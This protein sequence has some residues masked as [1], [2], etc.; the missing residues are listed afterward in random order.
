MAAR[1]FA[2][3]DVGSYELNL[4]IYE[5]QSGNMKVID[6]VVYRLDL[7]TDSYTKGKIPADKVTELIRILKEFA[8][9]MRS[10]RVSDYKAYG[11]SA[12]RETSNTRILLDQIEQRTNIHIDVLSN[13]EQRFLN[14]KSV[15]SKGGDFLKIIDNGT[16]II[17][18]GGGSIQLSL[19]DNDKLDMTQNVDIGVIRLLDRLK[20]IDVKPSR[21][22]EML[23]EMINSQLSVLNRLYLKNRKITNLII[24]DDYLSP[25]IWNRTRESDTPGYITASRFASFSEKLRQ[26]E[27]GEFA[28]TYSV[29]LENV[30]LVLVAAALMRNIFN[31]TGAEQ[32]WSPGAT[33]TDGIAYEYGEKKKL[34]TINH[35]FE[36]DIVACARGISRRYMGDDKR[37][38]NMEAICLAI[39]DSIKSIHGLNKRDRLIL[40]LAAIL[41]DC[42]KYISLH[43]LSDCSYDIIMSTEI[44]GL[45]HEEREILAGVVKH[46]H[47]FL[48]FDEDK[49]GINIYSDESYMRTAKL[50]AIL[51]LANGLDKSQKQK[52]TNIKASLK[53]P[54]LTLTVRTNKDL[55]LEKGLFSKRADFFEEIY[56]VRP[57]INQIAK[58]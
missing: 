43:N 9:I 13:S 40:R 36:E 26:M 37:A 5:F 52:V 34:I 2:A 46:N 15:A 25:I 54:V 45:S 38:S 1:M 3:I 4:K 51:R 22:G 33:L 57:V 39:Y 58:V 48:E 55:T 19:F 18:I 42:G 32:M 35:N 56:N 20:R 12:I 47:A 29:P 44:I 17:D 14:Y 24:L 30:E 7:G 49:S 6:S 27:P 53:G 11:T 41:H 28:R 10:Y 50:T 31:V 23:D 16:A 8:G 21:Y